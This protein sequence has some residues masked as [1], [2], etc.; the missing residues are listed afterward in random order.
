MARKDK[1]REKSSKGWHARF[2]PSTSIRPYIADALLLNHGRLKYRFLT[3]TQ[4]YRP[5]FS[6]FRLH[7]WHLP[8]ASTF[9]F[10]KYV[11]VLILASL[12]VFLVGCVTVACPSSWCFLVDSLF[13]CLHV[14]NVAVAKIWREEFFC[15]PYTTTAMNMCMANVQPMHSPVTCWETF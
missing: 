8:F 2:S 15:Q 10:L 9:P 14:A 12:H 3:L 4:S 11:F 13:D 5:I 6:S 1:C 7:L